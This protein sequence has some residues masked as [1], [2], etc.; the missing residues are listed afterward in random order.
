MPCAMPHTALLSGR[1]LNGRY[2]LDAVIGEGTFGRVY[3]GRDLR[4]ERAVAI[5][6][7]KPWWTEDPNWAKSFEREAQLMARVSHA[8]IVQIYDIGYADEGLYYVAELVE[9]QSLS[10][11]LRAGSLAPPEARDIAEQLCRALAQA[12]AKRVVHRDVKPANVLITAEGRV[13][14]GDFGIARLAEGTTDGAGGTIVG[15]P[16]YMAP[17]QARGRP[18]TPATDVYGV[19]VVLYEML[20]GRPPFTERA[21]VELA[22][23]HV[24]DPP[25]PLPTGTP[26][27]LAQIVE[28][29]LAKDPADR[30]PGAQQMAD[31]L[32]EADASEP[33]N[34]TVDTALFTDP[35]EEL[36]VARVAERGDGVA[37]TR[38][39]RISPRRNVNPAETKRY[40]AL[41]ACV[42]VIV[43]AG[44]VAGGI[45]LAKGSVRVPNL[46]GATRAAVSARLRKLGLEASFATAY[47]HA[48]LGLAIAQ[49]PRA[50]ANVSDGSTLRVTLSGG[51]PPVPVPQLVGRS[52]SSAEATLQQAGLNS[53]ATSVP[54]PGTTPGIVVRQSPGAGAKLTPRSTVALSVAESPRWRPLTSFSGDGSGHSVPFQIRGTRWQMVSNMSYDGTCLLIFVCSGPSVQVVN[55]TTGAT[56]DQFDLAGGNGQTQVFKTG[57]GLYEIKIRAGSDSASWSIGVDDYY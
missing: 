9:G 14:I 30:Y 48:P 10:A 25:P 53:T 56:V 19:G 4:L 7:I 20:A 13:K 43:L 31:A 2:E 41:L 50:G 54:S 51:P 26:P 45:L 36:T 22:L 40:R 15:T 28:R 27:A 5:K 55:P 38:V 23:R 16:R 39:K 37:P 18:T 34:R 11:R 29:A 47:S 42:V 17:E 12:H 57:P 24:S 46:R 6:V 3:R 49:S 52:E 44:L 33:R 8:G 21:A 1:A 35:S 32:A